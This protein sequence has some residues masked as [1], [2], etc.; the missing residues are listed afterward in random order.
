MLDFVSGM[1]PED[2]VSEKLFPHVFAW[3]ERYRAAVEEA[4]STASQPTALD[5]EAAAKHILESELGHPQ[6]PFDGDDP[7]R[8]KEGMQVEVYP[9]D[10]VTEHRDRG[11]LVGL[12]ADEVTIAVKSKGDVEIRIHAPRT[13]FKVR[14]I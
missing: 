4:K 7:A 10:W 14:E 1:L 12:T 3:L 5:G 6:I 11:Q 13:G 2:V 8:L 9:A